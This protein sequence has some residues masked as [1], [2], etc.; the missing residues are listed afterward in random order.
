MKGAPIRYSADELAWVKACS[1][2]P[3]KELHALFVQVWNR[4]EVSQS[5]L[6]ALCKRKGWLTGRSGQ[7]CKGQVS[8]NTGKK[9]LRYAGS[10]KGWFR[11]GERRGVATALYKPIGTERLS[12]CGYL[13]RKVNDALPLNRRWRAVHLINWEAVH[14][15]IPKGHALKSIDGNRL[16]TDPANWICIPR[17]MLP[18]LN[19]KSGRDYD[20]APAEVKPTILA[21]AK[22]E[23]RIAEA[24]KAAQE[25]GVVG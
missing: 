22:L 7:F 5:N 21:V 23:H 13:E 25:Q 12:K 18:R 11:P 16:N 10:E 14:G 6:S 3:R 9:G 17:A 1:D 15:P 2:L 8:H 19:C 20:H 4:P 24:V